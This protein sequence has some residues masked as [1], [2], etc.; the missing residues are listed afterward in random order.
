MVFRRGFGEAT[1]DY[2]FKTCGRG[3]VYGLTPANNAKA[4]KFNKH[5]G[6][7]EI[8][9]LED[10]HIVGVDLVLQELTKE[11]YYGKAISSRAA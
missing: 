5:F 1:F 11:R 3:K 8:F 9:R 10:A 2:V 7:V 6:L 4:L